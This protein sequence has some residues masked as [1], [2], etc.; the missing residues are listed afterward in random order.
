MR[1]RWSGISIVFVIGILGCFILQETQAIQKEERKVDPI[2]LEVSKIGRF[3][4]VHSKDL[5]PP[6]V[7]TRGLMLDTESGKLYVLITKDGEPPLQWK[8]VAEA[9]K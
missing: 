2:K 7:E 9:P 6:L 3:Q 4:V 5:D 8:L 1:F